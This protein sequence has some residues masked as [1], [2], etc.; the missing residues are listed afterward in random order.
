MV[1]LDVVINPIPDLITHYTSDPV[2]KM[3]CIGSIAAV[4][5]AVVILIFV[6][7]GKK[8]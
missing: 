3:I 7:K 8:D 6:K 1:N 5:I 4:V 2:G